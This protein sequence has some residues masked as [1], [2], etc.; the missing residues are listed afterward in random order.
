MAVAMFNVFKNK[1]VTPPK[2]VH[3]DYTGRNIIVTGATSGLGVEAVFKFARLGA[4]KVI[5]AARDVKKGESTKSA[6]EARLGRRGQLQVWELDMMSYDSVEA[7]AN[8]ANEELDHLDI[9]VLNAGTRRVHF[10][11]SK[12]G[13]EEDIQVNTLSTILLAILLLPKLK[14]SKQQSSKIPILEFVN[15]GLHQNAIVPP[16]VRQTNVLDHYNKKENHKEGSQYSFS[17][18]F[19]MYATKKLADEI[20]S[21]DVIITSICP[22]WVNTDLGRDHFFPGIHILAFFFIFLFMRSPAVAA[23]M[24]LSGTTQGESLHGRFWRH[25]K[26]Q[27]N[28]PSLTGP[29][30]KELSAKMWVEIVDALEKDVP[31]FSKAMD[32]ALSKR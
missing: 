18:V 19:L 13:W 6:L 8:R 27:P 26:I 11:Q 23:N 1:W 20:S 9:A 12:Y 2:D 21:G 3:E 22:G 28:G 5:I 29:D 24:V 7:F 14:K 16:E 32:A 17:K 15:S 30:M 25:D 4:T 31:G 10:V